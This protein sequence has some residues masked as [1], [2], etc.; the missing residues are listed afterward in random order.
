MN[1]TATR[2]F[3]DT[4]DIQRHYERHNG[5]HWFEPQAMR[6]FGTRFGMTYEGPGGVFFV[7]TERQ[8]KGLLGPPVPGRKASVRRY[9]PETL[10]ISTVGKFHSLTEDTANELAAQ[11]AAEG[12]VDADERNT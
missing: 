12:V 4:G 1:E 11:Y 3:W 10:D 9:N 5:G 7:T 2:Q 8:S 6:F